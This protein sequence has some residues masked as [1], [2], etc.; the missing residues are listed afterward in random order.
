MAEK[1][2]NKL[3]A[4]AIFARILAVILVTAIGGVA[5]FFGFK[6]Y[7]SD[8]LKKDKKAEIAKQ[9]KEESKE[10]VDVGM[11][12]TGNSI[13]IRIY[14]NKNQEMIFVPLRQDMNLTL[15]KKGKQ[16]V[17]QTLGTSVSKATVA[18]VIKATRKNGKLLRQQVEKTLGI[19]INSYELIS[20]K[21]FVKLM[22]QAGD[23]KIEFDEAMAYTDSTDKY[24]TLSA[25]ENS[26][27]GTAIYSLLS[28]SDIFTD[29]NKQAEITGE[30]CVAVASALNDKTLSEYREYAQNYFDAVKTDASYEEAAT[31]LERMHGIK[32]KNL[33]FKV[34]DGTESNGKF[35]LDT[36]EAKRVFD[37]MLSEEG[38][39]SSA[40]STTEAKSTT[41][42]SDSSASSS[43]NITIDSE[44]NK[45]LRTCRKMER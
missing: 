7:F 42:K 4:K 30:I 5:S 28:E 11:I 18:D 33:N 10:R 29:K 8:K 41:T 14:H 22:N 12:Q 6:T 37:E 40:L 1:K 38:D 9:L 23:V 3:G 31:S 43:K 24:V 16:A 20:H 19:S 44:F 39:L 25:G 17:E 45:N 35:E 26:L 15:T 32:D 2:K 36:E 27:N 21:K 13:V 34:L